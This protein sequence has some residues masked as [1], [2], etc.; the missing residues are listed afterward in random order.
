[1]AALYNWAK[2]QRRLPRGFDAP[3]RHIEKQVESRGRVR[4]LS[5]DERDRLLAACRALPSVRPGVR[6]LTGE[7]RI[8]PG[9][10]LPAR[11]VIHTVGPVWH[12]GHAGEPERLAACH[13]AAF[14]LAVEKRLASLAFPAISCGVYGYPALRAAAVA[15]QTLHALLR[16]SPSINVTLC[17]FSEAMRQVFQDAADA[18]G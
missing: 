7:A 8:T 10:D 1:M 3:T 5:D 15:T 6:C 2:R 14:A 16:T 11:W 18:A 17:C 13:R 9:F 12:G 4:F